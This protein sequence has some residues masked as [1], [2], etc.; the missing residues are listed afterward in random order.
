MNIMIE[1]INLVE[2]MSISTKFIQ[3]FEQT[4]Y[5]F[6][7]LPPSE[8]DNN[9]IAIQKLRYT[10]VQHKKYIFPYMNTIQT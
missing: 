2:P 6:N 3:G 10:A 4:E 5:N 7:S 9:V 1:T 8:A